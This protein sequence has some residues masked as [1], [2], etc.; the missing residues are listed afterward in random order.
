MVRQVD[1]WWGGRRL[2]A[3]LP[4]LWFQHFT[5][6]SW[7]AEDADGPA[8]RLPRRIRQPGPP[9]RGV[10]P[11]GRR[12]PEPAAARARPRRS[13]SGSSPTPRAAASAGSMP[14]PGPATGSRS[15]STGR[16]GSPRRRDRA[17][18]TST[19][20]RPTRTTT[21]RRG[22]GRRSAGRRCDR[23]PGV[24]C[25][26]SRRPNRAAR[27]AVRDRVQPAAQERLALGVD[28]D[29]RPPQRMLDELEPLLRR[30]R[31]GSGRRPRGSRGPPRA[32]ARRRGA[33]ARRCRG[34]RLRTRRGSS[35]ATD[36]SAASR[37][38]AGSRRDREPG[39]L[40]QLDEQVDEARLGGAANPAPT[41]A[42][43]SL[44]RH[45]GVLISRIDASSRPPRS[46][47]SAS[48]Q[49]CSRWWPGIRLV[50]DD[51][52]EVRRADRAGPC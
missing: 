41:S 18:R 25:S 26:W 2:H 22:S 40:E 35:R 5:G 34:S 23:R 49:A 52:D 31:G 11:H 6:T 51:V 28:E 7:I 14:S 50:G 32:T 17:R 20:R 33:A 10:H 8:G 1:D 39:P 27:S 4:R 3:L 47:R 48:F 21:P 12:E 45:S 15:G 30:R 36:R 24:S 16:W 37:A 19:A 29:V 42:S 9:R 43:P 38:A 13:T 44:I 46:T